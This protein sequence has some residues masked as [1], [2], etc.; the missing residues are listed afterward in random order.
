MILIRK[1][2]RVWVILILVTMLYA[3]YKELTVGLEEKMTIPSVLFWILIVWSLFGIFYTIKMMDKDI[4][5]LVK[6]DK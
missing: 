5:E 1:I 2:F 6:E 4:K 3:I